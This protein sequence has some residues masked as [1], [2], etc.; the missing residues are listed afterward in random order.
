MPG[1]RQAIR[2]TYLSQEDLP[3][4]IVAGDHPDMARYVR[5]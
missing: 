5:L 1:A 4:E 2:F 3:E